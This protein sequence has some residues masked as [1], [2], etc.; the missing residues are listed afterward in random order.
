MCLLLLDAPERGKP[1]GSVGE[2]TVASS[3][4]WKSRWLSGE[5]DRRVLR[6][7]AAEEVGG[8]GLMTCVWSWVS[9]SARHPTPASGLAEASSHDV[10]DAEG[11][12]SEPLGEDRTCGKEQ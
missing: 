10:V 11:L 6:V 3:W 7:H 5:V 2:I 4:H 9:H 8:V 12:D 1:S